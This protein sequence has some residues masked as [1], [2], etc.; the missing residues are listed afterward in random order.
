MRDRNLNVLLACLVI[1]ICG[2]IVLGDFSTKQWSVCSALIAMSAFVVYWTDLYL[3][4]KA[5]PSSSW[6][7]WV[8]LD[9]VSA[10]GMYTKN[11]LNGLVLIYTIGATLTAIFLLWRDGMSRWTKW[12]ISC[13]IISVIGIILWI[14]F[15]RLPMDLSWTG[16]TGVQIGVACAQFSGIVGSI[17]MWISIYKKPDEENRYA[18]AIWA[19][20]C[21][22]GLM[23]VSE[24]VFVK[25]AAPVT[26]TVIE[27]VIL[28]LI[29]TGLSRKLR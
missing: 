1:S 28:V 22:A 5:S 6:I 26:F 12:D 2:M 27:W 23:A 13:T 19:F 14:A 10:V 3:N 17:P 7:V 24:W 16:L 11:E 21:I 9:W 4:K 18:W 15:E 25:F 8:L 29:Y 20:S